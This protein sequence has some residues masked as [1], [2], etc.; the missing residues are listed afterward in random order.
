MC[1]RDRPSTARRSVGVCVERVRLVDRVEPY[2]HMSGCSARL[3][4]PCTPERASRDGDGGG[5]LGGCLPGVFAAAPPGQVLVFVDSTYL[6]WPAILRTAEAAAPGGW[7]GVCPHAH[8]HQHA[9]VL[10]RAAE[11]RVCAPLRKRL[12]PV[13][14][15]LARV[16]SHDALF[17]GAAGSGAATTVAFSAPSC[18]SAPFC[19]SA[20]M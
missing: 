2:L 11:G 15:C 16:A 20:P 1:I 12:A 19:A 10:V 6:L 8:A 13:G 7:H 5:T 18:S 14:R 9:V 17:D 3:K 4:A